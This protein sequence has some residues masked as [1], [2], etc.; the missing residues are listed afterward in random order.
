MF[1]ILLITSPGDH[2]T[3][4]LV[5]GMKSRSAPRFRF[6]SGQESFRVGAVYFLL[7][8]IR[9]HIKTGFLSSW[10]IKEILMRGVR[11]FQPDPSL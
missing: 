5:P 3:V 1:R 4:P 8:H 6:D 11:C 10:L 2:L 9:R 7:P